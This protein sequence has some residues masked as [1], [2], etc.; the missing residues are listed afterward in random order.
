MTARKEPRKGWGELVITSSLAAGVAGVLSLVGVARTQERE[1]DTQR[2]Q[3]AA[4]F[5]QDETLS[6]YI[7]ATRQK[8]LVE[9]A[10][11]SLEQCLGNR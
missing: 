2:C 9:L 5:L 8:R 10:A 6:P 7:D 3:M 1:R 11:R 4:T